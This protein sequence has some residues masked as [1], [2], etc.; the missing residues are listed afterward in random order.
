MT[1]R[2]DETARIDR[3]SFPESASI[4]DPMALA[5]VVAADYEVSAPLRCQL[6]SRGMNDA[7]HSFSWY[8]S[9]GSWLS[10]AKTEVDGLSSG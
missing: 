4:L 1:A 3:G 9:S 8:G 7:C 10:I 2:P 5:K 6:V